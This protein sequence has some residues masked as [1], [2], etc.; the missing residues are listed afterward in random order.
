MDVP[1]DWL[2][3]AILG[4]AAWRT[5]NLLAHDKILDRPRRWALRLDPGW[6][7]P[8]DATGDDYRLKWAIFLT[9]PYC[10]G[11]WIS[12][13]WFAAYQVSEFWTLFAAMAFVLN[14]I[15]VALAKIL[16][17]ED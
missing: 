13:A 15:V 6:A 8:G 17:P 3:I 4:I 2:T 12:V 9:C 11:F 10:A 16:T 14:A 7:K 5:F 1:G